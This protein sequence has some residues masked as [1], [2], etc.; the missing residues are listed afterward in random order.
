MWIGQRKQTLRSLKLKFKGWPRNDDSA[1]Y[2]KRSTRDKREGKK[3]KGKE[4]RM[5][6]DEHSQ[7]AV[8]NLFCKY[9]AFASF[10]PWYS[11]SPSL[12]PDYFG[13]NPSWT[14]CLPMAHLQSQ[15]LFFHPSLLP[16]FPPVQLTFQSVNLY[17]TTRCHTPK[18]CNINILYSLLLYVHVN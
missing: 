18:Y 9:R 8:T 11:L 10:P 12:F 14:H 15:G 4:W 16:W 5:I 13:P 6:T 1:R 3:S 7:N 2:Q 17:Q